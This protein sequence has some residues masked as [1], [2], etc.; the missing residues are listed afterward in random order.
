MSNSTPHMHHTASRDI[1]A[2]AVDAV[3]REYP[4]ISHVRAHQIVQDR[5]KVRRRMAQRYTFVPYDCS[6]HMAADAFLESYEQIA[7]EQSA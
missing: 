5:A 4:G 1:P 3:L 2:N 7:T 6:D